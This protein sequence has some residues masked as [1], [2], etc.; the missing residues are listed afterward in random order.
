MAHAEILQPRGYFCVALPQAK[1]MQPYM[2]EYLCVDAKTFQPRG[3]LSVA[4]SRQ[5][6]AAPWVS[7]WGSR[8][9]IAAPWLSLYGSR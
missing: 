6:I 8:Q 5:N 4:S 7:L 3:Y 1:T 2:Y 9:N